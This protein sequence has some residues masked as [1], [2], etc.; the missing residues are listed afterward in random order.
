MIKIYEGDLQDLWSILS[1][2]F[3]EVVV[4]RFIRS[5]FCDLFTCMSILHCFTEFT[6]HVAA[7]DKFTMTTFCVTHNACVVP[8]S[9]A[10]RIT[11]V[12]TFGVFL[13]ESSGGAQNSG[14]RIRS[15]VIR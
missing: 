9:T 2:T 3:T 5:T 6:F 14:L 8:T 13:T 15:A 4:E 10:Q 1:G 7:P 12:R 11:T